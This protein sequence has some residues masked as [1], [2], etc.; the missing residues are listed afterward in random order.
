M[1]DREVLNPAGVTPR[2][3]PEVQVTGAVI[4]MVRAGMGLAV[5]PLWALPAGRGESGSGSCA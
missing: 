1:F 3:V 5:L 2:R 4:E